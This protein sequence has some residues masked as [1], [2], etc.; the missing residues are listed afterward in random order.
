MPYDAWLARFRLCIDAEQAAD[1]AALRAAWDAAPPTAIASAE[2]A[3]RFDAA[4]AG[5]V[6]AG[7]ADAQRDLLL[8]LED[9]AAIEPPESDRGRRM[10]LRLA[11]LSGHLRG[12]AGAESEVEFS[13]LLEDWTRIASNSDTDGTRR[14]EVAFETIVRNIAATVN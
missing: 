8:E 13:R 6:V 10:Q 12:T 14:F 7:S 11:K 2:L 1:A 4:L 5:D 3:A 9:Q